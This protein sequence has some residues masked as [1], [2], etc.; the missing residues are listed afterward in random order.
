MHCR[1]G[2]QCTA[3]GAG[4]ALQGGGTEQKDI[5]WELGAGEGRGGK[6]GD[7]EGDSKGGGKKKEGDVEEGGKGTKVGRCERT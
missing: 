4:S 5:R 6:G 1:G 7:R 2:R 3:G